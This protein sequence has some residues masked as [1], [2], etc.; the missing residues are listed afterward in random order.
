MSMQSLIE[1]SDNC[2][3]ISGSLWQYYRDEPSA[4]LRNSE[5]FKFKVRMTES[6]AADGNT[7][8]VKTAMPLN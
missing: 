5:S 8:D 1:Y 7:K 6:T 4:T 3:K 2:P